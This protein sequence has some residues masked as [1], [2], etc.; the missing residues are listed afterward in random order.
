MLYIVPL[1]R[2]WFCI[3]HSVPTPFS[4]LLLMDDFEDFENQVEEATTN[5]LEMARE[6]ELE[7]EPEDVK[8]SLVSEDKTLTDKD[9]LLIDEQ[10]RMFCKEESHPDDSPVVPLEMTSRGL[11]ALNCI[12]TGW[13]LLRGLSKI[14]KE[15][16]KRMQAFY[17]RLHAIKKF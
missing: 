9:L 5:V 8:E 4:Y 11:E 3:A 13:Q 2:L 14:S 10:R 6:L 15:V 1:H 17:T 16:L 12:E 7:V